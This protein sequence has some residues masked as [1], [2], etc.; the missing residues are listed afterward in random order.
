MSTL[1]ELAQ[2]TDGDVVA[3][4]TAQVCLCEDKGTWIYIAP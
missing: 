1:L 3:L 2:Q 4:S